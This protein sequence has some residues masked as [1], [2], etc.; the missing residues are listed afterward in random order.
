MLLHSQGTW[1]QGVLCLGFPSWYYP[2]LQHR[3]VG[4][5]LK[6][7][8]NTQP[9]LCRAFKGIKESRHLHPAAVQ[10]K[11]RVQ[12]FTRC[13]HLLQHP[14]L[15]EVPQ[16]AGGKKAGLWRDLRRY[17]IHPE[18]LTEGHAFVALTLV[19][20]GIDMDKE[21]KRNLFSPNISASS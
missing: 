9:L 3:Q 21:R 8:Q 7:M 14:P 13:L 11:A 2:S 1:W 18:L 15:W 5:C 4:P 17:C 20:M 16:I 10:W 19:G 6:T 12:L